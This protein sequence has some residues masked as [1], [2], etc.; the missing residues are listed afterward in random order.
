[1]QI[2]GGKPVA[3]SLFRSINIEEYDAKY[4]GF[5]CLINFFIPYLGIIDSLIRYIY[6]VYTY[7]LTASYMTMW[8]DIKENISD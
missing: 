5:V 4:I 8:K 6:I 3:P 2:Q 7:N 1:M